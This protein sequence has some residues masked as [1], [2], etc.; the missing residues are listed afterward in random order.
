MKLN[1]YGYAN[2]NFKRNVFKH[3]WNCTKSRLFITHLFLFS[4]LTFIYVLFIEHNTPLKFLYLKRKTYIPGSLQ[5]SNLLKVT[6]RKRLVRRK[7]KTVQRAP[8][9]H[10]Q[11]SQEQY[12]FVFY[13]YNV[14]TYINLSKIYLINPSTL[15]HSL[16]FQLNHLPGFLFNSSALNFFKVF[17]SHPF[18]YFLIN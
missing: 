2:Y 1:L 14:F 9:A 8:M 10:R 16:L 4:L 7:W 6:L 15:D 11:W 17:Y 13:T 3:I 5:R 18:N 12:E